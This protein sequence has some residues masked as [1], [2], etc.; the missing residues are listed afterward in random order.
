MFGG[1]FNWRFY[2]AA[3]LLLLLPLAL[4]IHLAKLQVIESK[5]EDDRGFAF[6]QKQGDART[7]R[8]EPI[9]AYRGNITDRNGELLAV[10][11]PVKTL[12]LNPEV[13]PR[14]QLGLIAESL[15]IDHDKLAA[16]FDRYQNK[17]FMYVARHLPPYKAQRA[18]D[19][20]LAGL[21][22]IDEFRRFYP[23]GEIAAHVV[24]FT[25]TDDRGREGIELAYNEWLEGEEG[26][27]QVLKDRQ[28][29]VIK[30]D[31]LIK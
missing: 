15:S 30:S 13:F 14:D 28:G 8:R 21:F 4:L 10:S 22:A 7:V 31:G 16:R 1:S 18:M 6:L 3:G 9:I 5:R 20:D 29:K 23:A 11:T 27:R 2:L 17:Q 12:Y 26:V 25:D 19:L 24:G